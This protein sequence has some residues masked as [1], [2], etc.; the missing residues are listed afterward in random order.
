M[1]QLVLEAPLELYIVMHVDGQFFSHLH[2]GRGYHS[3]PQPVN[4][5]NINDAKIYSKIGP[6]RARMSG[7]R[8]LPGSGDYLLVKILST[9]CEVIDE[10]ARI[11]KAADAKAKKLAGQEKR[12]AEYARKRAE[13]AL[14]KAQEVLDNLNR[15]RS[16]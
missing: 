12:N 6:A 7:L 5:T 13:E 9:S 10:T 8:V 16:K 4:V 14:K 1:V 3:L 11:Q 2:G 15:K